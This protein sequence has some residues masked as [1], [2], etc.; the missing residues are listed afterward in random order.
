MAINKTPLKKAAT[1]CLV[2]SFLGT[3]TIQPAIA[4]VIST[5]ALMTSTA[6]QMSQ[7]PI[8]QVLARD[9]VRAQLVSLGV[10]P[11]AAKARIAALSPDELAQLN[12]RVGELPAGAGVIGVLGVL[13]LVLL[14]L[15]ILGVT[16]VF[17][18]I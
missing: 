3:A 12:Q 6:R 15:E 1:L 8:D 5:E 16:N 14:V 17:S 2:A 11:D 7:S 18:K 9:D 4:S 10:D 13:L